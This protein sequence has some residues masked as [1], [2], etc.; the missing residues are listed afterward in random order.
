MSKPTIGFVGLGAMGFGMA[1][2]L[3]NQGYPV[4]G[5]DV[6]PASVDRFKS[7]AGNGASSLRDSAEGKNFYVCMVA[8]A[9]QVQS[10]LFEGGIID[11]MPSHHTTSR[12]LYSLSHLTNHTSTPPKRH[13]IS[14]LDHPRLLRSVS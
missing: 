13:I 12:P 2:H 8:S 14:L 5:F 11:G 4:H 7:S 10:V 6:F 3:V 9:A 1:T